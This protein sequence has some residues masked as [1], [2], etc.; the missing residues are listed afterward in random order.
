MHLDVIHITVPLSEA[1]YHRPPLGWIKRRAKHL[2]RAYGITRRL[3]IASAAD[4]YSTFTH[5]RR[6]RLSQLL[7]GGHHH[8]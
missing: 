3:A 7:K 6:E 8:A 1:D 2:Q 4:D 5:M